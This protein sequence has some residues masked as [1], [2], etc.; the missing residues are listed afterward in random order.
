MKITID[1][2]KYNLVEIV[3]QKVDQEREE[4]IANIKTTIQHEHCNA[5]W[6]DYSVAQALYDKGYRKVGEEVSQEELEKFRAVR[7][8][9]SYINVIN[10]L[11]TQYSITK[12]V[13]K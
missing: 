4:T 1:G 11:R 6:D 13:V 7:K 10:E 9:L 3:E 5:E 8:G 12:K 2:I